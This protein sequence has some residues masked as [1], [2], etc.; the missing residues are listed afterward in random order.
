MTNLA[1]VTVKPLMRLKLNQNI[2]FKGP[3]IEH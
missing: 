2:V 1:S 3:D